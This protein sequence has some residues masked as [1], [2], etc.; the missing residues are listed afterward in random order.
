MKNNQPI[1][2]LLLIVFAAIGFLGGMKYQQSKTPTTSNIRGQFAGGA[3]QGGVAGG[4]RG[5]QIVGDI[6]NA[7]T[8]T[9]TIKLTDG[10]SKIIFLSSNSIIIKS[11][12]A[13]ISD[14]TVGTKVGVFGQT[15]PDGSVTAQN[16]S[17]NPVLRIMGA[18]P[19]A[20]PV[21]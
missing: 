12:Q 1:I 9:I 3:R 18:T 14:L 17:L 7:D 21:R 13:D 6:I 8:K 4:N 20:T 10:S 15:N 2:G 19:S 5:G 16:I 11:T